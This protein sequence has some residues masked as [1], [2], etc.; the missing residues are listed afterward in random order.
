[1]FIL[2]FVNIEKVKKNK[3]FFCSFHLLGVMKRDS[4]RCRVSIEK[5]YRWERPKVSEVGAGE[6]SSVPRKEVRMDPGR[7]GERT[8]CP[9]I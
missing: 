4:P 3:D 2:F 5:S 9:G 8:L 6:H 7:P 1:M